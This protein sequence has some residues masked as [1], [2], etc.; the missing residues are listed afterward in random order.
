LVNIFDLIL[1]GKIVSAE[2]KKQ[3]ALEVEA[4]LKT[5]KRA[6]HL[7]AILIGEN[8]AS[9]TYVASK[10][11]NCKEVGFNSSVLRF[12]ESISEKELLNKIIEINSDDSID[13]LIVQLPLPKHINVQKVTETISPV[14]D[15]DGFHPLN[16]GRL[17]Q[18]LPCYIPATPYG[19]ILMLQHYKIETEGKHCVVLGRSNI[20]GMPMSIL[21]S[22]N[23]S[24]GNCTVTICHSK[25]KNLSDI[26]RSADILIA[27]LGHPDFVKADM[28][29]KNAVVIDVGITRVP[30]SETKSGFKLTGDV[31]FA[32]ASKIASY[33]TPVPGGVGLMTIAGLLKNTMAARLGTINF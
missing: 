16:T 33:I 14:K 23:A 21:M 18:N 8:G 28:L 26:T 5:G 6:P 13:G 3:L 9:E 11:K 12:P 32:E 10:E 17:M 30:S 15:V 4:M 20:V 24:P 7:C 25:T 27:A 2:I 1:D 22:R 19:I 31:D 29:M